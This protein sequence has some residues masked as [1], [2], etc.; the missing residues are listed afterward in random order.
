MSAYGLIRFDVEDF[1]TT[2]SD[3]ALNAVLGIMEDTAMPAS[4]GLVGKKILSLQEHHRHDILARLSRQRAIGF[5]SFSH[6]EHPT[7]AEDLAGRDY[8][9]GVEQFVKREGPG[10]ELVRDAIASPSY[11]TQPGGNWVPEACDALPQLGMPV[12]FSDSWNSYL[13]TDTRPVW[14]EDILHLALPVISPKPFAMKLPD[15]LEDALAMLRHAAETMRAPEAFMVMVHPT[16]LVTTKFW[17]AVNFSYGAT[18]EHLRPA[19]LRSVSERAQAIAAFREYIQ[20]ARA[21]PNIEWL[22]LPG[23]LSKLESPGAVRLPSQGDLAGA[24]RASGLGPVSLNAQSLS[25][26]DMV[27]AMA[28]WIAGAG[29]EGLELP[30]AKAPQFWADTPEETGPVGEAALLSGARAIMAT[31]SSTQRIPGSVTLGGATLPIEQWFRAALHAPREGRPETVPLT[32]LQQVK[33]PSDLHW[34]W[35]IFPPDFRPVG[36]WNQTRRLAWSIKPVQ[37][38]H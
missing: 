15:N 28:W 19:P 17:D 3:D 33:A 8:A 23:F 29:R 9:S 14:I 32:F 27:A 11:F 7:L 2:E 20:A 21:L 1:I 13:A 31:V 25:A 38:R 6:S 34:D 4:Y 35:P 30:R 12:F 16:E 5:H 26:A 18:C 10:V 24:V 37:Y 36:L 22:D